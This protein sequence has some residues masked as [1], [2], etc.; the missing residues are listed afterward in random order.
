MVNCS[1]TLAGPFSRTN[2]DPILPPPKISKRRPD[3]AVH[4]NAWTLTSCS[5][6]MAATVRRTIGRS[7]CASKHCWGFK[8]PPGIGR[9]IST[10]FSR[11]LDL[12][13][14]SLPLAM[15]IHLYHAI[16]SF[17]PDILT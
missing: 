17:F 9:E 12:E 2:R 3:A 15:N 6:C 1:V 13:G 11:N 4:S 14:D 10:E 7:F 8:Q 16:V 5:G